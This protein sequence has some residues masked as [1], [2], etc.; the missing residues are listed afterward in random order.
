MGNFECDSYVRQLKDLDFISTA[1][2][3]SFSSL[4]HARS[5]APPI[6]GSPYSAI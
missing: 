1:V 4:P 6:V 2:N 3:Y 5:K